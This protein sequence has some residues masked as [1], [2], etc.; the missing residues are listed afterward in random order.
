MHNGFKCL[1][2]TVSW[3]KELFKVWNNIGLQFGPKLP[4]CSVLKTEG[5]LINYNYYTFKSRREADYLIMYREQLQTV[6]TNAVKSA[7]MVLQIHVRC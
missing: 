7:V 6:Y 4:L 3:G 5:K 2:N 1:V